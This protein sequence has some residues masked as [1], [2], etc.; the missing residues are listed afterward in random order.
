M[1]TTWIDPDT[2]DKY[3]FITQQYEVGLYVAIYKNSLIDNQ[4]GIDD[5][6]A[7]FHKSLRENMEKENIEMLA[8]ESSILIGE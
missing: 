3:K 8:E 1:V 6:E 4:F 2:K 5:T 7:E